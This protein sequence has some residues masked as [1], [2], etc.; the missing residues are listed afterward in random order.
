PVAEKAGVSTLQAKLMYEQMVSSPGNNDAVY[1]LEQLQTRRLKLTEMGQQFEQIAVAQKPA[2]A[3]RYLFQSLDAFKGAGSETDELRVLREIAQL[4]PLSGQFQDRYFELLLDKDPQRLLQIAGDP[5]AH[6]DAAVNFLMAH[7]DA[8][9]TLSAVEARSASEPPVWRSAYM[10]LTGLYF[11]DRSLPVQNAFAS[12]L[13][14]DTIAQRL[15]KAGNRKQALAGDVWFYYGSRYGEYLGLLKKGDPEDFLPA[16]ME[17]TPNRAAPYFNTAFYYEEAGDLPRAINDYQHVVEIDSRRI[18]AHNRLAGIYWK[19]KQEEPALGEWKRALELLKVQTTTSTT[20][21]TFW[22]DFAAT[23]NSLASRKLLAQ[24]QPGVNEVLHNYVKRNGAYRLDPL[25]RSVLAHAENPGAAS[26][27]LLELSADAP[28]K[29]SFLRQFLAEQ[30]GFKIDREPIFR[31]VLELAREAAQRAEGS[32]HEYAQQEF[33]GFEIQ[34]LEYLLESKQ[35]DRLRG[36]MA[37][38]PKSLWER[39]TELVTLQLKVAAQSAG[40]DAVLG[41]YRADSEH[42]PSA[43]VLRKTATELQQAGDKQSA[44]KILEFVFTREI[45]NHDL[46][47]A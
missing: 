35:M 19:Q 20:L 18:D 22:G 14:D 6:G 1:P 24:F 26:A 38:L 3:T 45:E 4:Q 32:A 10:A 25:L 5:N 33:E 41:E 27:L 31:R 7:A 8:K 9:L 43:Q 42:A 47:A 29:L 30:S 46:T 12:A 36:E 21:E 2:Y 28:E 44:R 13:A 11:G 37:T 23:V 17:H 40:L 16:E 34:W 39:R 15:A